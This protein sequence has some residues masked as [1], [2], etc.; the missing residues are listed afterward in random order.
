LESSL[1]QS[2]ENGTPELFATELVASIADIP[3]FN[4]KDIILRIKI[5]ISIF[6]TSFL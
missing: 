1:L 4:I 2:T 6:I 3:V 5:M